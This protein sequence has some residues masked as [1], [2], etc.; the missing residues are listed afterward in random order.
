MLEVRDIQ[1]A[2]QNNTVLD[3]VSFTLSPGQCLG[4]AGHNGS[5]KSTLLSIIAQVLPPDNGLVLFDGVDL[6]ENRAMASAILSYAPQEDSLLDDLTVK[7]TLAFWQK[8][9]GLPVNKLFGDLSPAVAFGLDRIRKKRVG[10]LS[11]GMRKR[12]NIVIALLRQPK[13]LLLDE[14]FSSLDRYYRLALEDY[15]KSF[16]DGGGSILYC[17]HNVAE[18]IGLCDR[19]LVLRDGRKVFDED[20]GAFPGDSAELDRLLNPESLES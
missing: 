18:L 7:E 9:Y 1:K 4:I 14:A 11:G 5:G 20:I 12:V 19:I 10:K 13:L 17:S 2:Y 8:V 6:S 15:L 16:R 3:Q